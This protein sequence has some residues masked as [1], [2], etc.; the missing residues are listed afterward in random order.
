MVLMKYL[1]HQNLPYKSIIICDADGIGKGEEQI[2]DAEICV[3]NDA[4][5]KM[6]FPLGGEVEASFDGIWRQNRFLIE[7]D[8]PII[9]V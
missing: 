3:S 2:D 8:D 9:V 4:L 7:M 5:T 1:N 6:E